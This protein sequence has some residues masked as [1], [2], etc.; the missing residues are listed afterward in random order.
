MP[1]RYKL[2]L[3]DGTLLGVD[4]E[5]L[6]TWA[7]DGRAMVQ[8]AVTGQ[9][10]PLREF[11][12]RERAAARRA[13]R[14]KAGDPLPPGQARTL[15]LVYPKP[16]PDGDL[17]PLPYAY[18]KRPLYDAPPSTP[19]TVEAAEP[20][21][22]DE[23]TAV[24]GLTEEPAAETAGPPEPFPVSE[25]ATAVATLEA[26]DEQVEITDVSLLSISPGSVESTPLPHLPSLEA[27]AEEPVA[28]LRELSSLAHLVDSAVPGEPVPVLETPP[29]PVEALV[30]EAP[31]ADPVEPV[32]ELAWIPDEELV[33]I[34]PPPAAGGEV[35]D[36]PAFLEVFD[37]VELPSPGEPVGVQALAEEPVR[38][39]ALS[40]SSQPAADEG[41]LPGG[42]EPRHHELPVIQLKPLED[43]THAGL[44]VY[45][46]VKG[47]VLAETRPRVGLEEKLAIL[48]ARTFA[49]CGPLL[50]RWIDRLGRWLSP[51]SP[52]LPAPALPR[53]YRQASSWLDG[54]SHGAGRA[55]RQDRSSPLASLNLPATPK[56]LG[57]VSHAPL[58]PPPLVSE[59]PV[60]RF[61][62]VP[63]EKDVELEEGESVLHTAGRW[64]KRLAVTSGLVAGGLYAAL[65]WQAW[66]P[67]LEQL[68]RAAFTEVDRLDQ[69]ERQR[70]ALLEAT[71][72]LPHLAGRTIQQVLATSPTGVL[73]PPEVF[74][75]ASDAADR[76]QPALTAG[77]AQELKGIREELLDSLRASERERVRE[78]DEARGRRAVFPFEARGVAELVARGAEALPAERRERLRQL[79]GK[80][81]ASGLVPPEEAVP[82]STVR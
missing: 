4:L 58:Q 68:G 55:A 22:L 24:L 2:R 57:L 53:L 34:P 67:K 76:G 70:Q 73:D 62:N 66:V 17:K 15:P 47:E 21:P 59:L 30:A 50:T 23:P 9:W 41:I 37:A 29:D 14:A 27:A 10:Q 32:P 8:S 60:L 46:G 69:A 63:E 44:G 45:E 26:R 33:P 39:D 78:Y 1:Q 28:P 6:T 31:P 7:V 80:S 72:R 20:A 74:R 64:A 49:A 11:L 19:P 56:G 82:R 42:P 65:T 16:L 25:D 36:D 48:V 18:P 54:L 3:G 5:A 12:A 75:L 81:I 52:G 71:D 40:V 13:D 79:L 61:A 43:E 35:T 77:E 51:A 38:P